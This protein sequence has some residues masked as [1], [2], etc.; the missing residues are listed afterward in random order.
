MDD[1]TP[2]MAVQLTSSFCRL[3]IRN[4]PSVALIDLFLFSSL[5]ADGVRWLSLSL[6]MEEQ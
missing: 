1:E 3:C 2:L 6:A 4:P 5:N